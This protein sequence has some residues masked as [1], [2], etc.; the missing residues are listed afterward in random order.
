MSDPI[1]NRIAVIGL[2]LIG[3]SFAAAARENGLARSIVAGSRSERTLEQGIALGVVDE[4][5]QDLAEAVDGADLVFVSTPV[6]AMGKVLAALKPGLSGTAIVTDGGSVK[7]NVVTAAREALGEHFSR[8][9]PGHPIAGQE[10]SGVTGADA[11]V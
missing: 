7:G 2:G 11:Q 4:G 1:F 5:S 9:V 3:G 10:N 8:F 6:S